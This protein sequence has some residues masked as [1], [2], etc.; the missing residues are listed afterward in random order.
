[1]KFQRYT[2]FCFSACILGKEKIAAQGNF[3]EYINSIIHDY[4]Y[5]QI[6]ILLHQPSNANIL[7][8]ISSYSFFLLLHDVN[9]NIP[10]HVLPIR[11]IIFFCIIIIIIIIIIIRPSI[12]AIL[13][14]L[15]LDMLSYKK[16]YGTLLL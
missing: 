2:C 6:V 15:Y 1:M 9:R 14:Y 11:K 8:L 4:S 16:K 7:I 10:I 12:T 13:K 3:H 5:Y